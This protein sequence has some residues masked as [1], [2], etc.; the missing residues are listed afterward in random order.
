MP[1]DQKTHI[2]TDLNN[3]C[4]HHIP[5]PDQRKRMALIRQ[6]CE[7]TARFIRDNTPESR[8]Q[9]KAIGYLTDEVMMMLLSN[10]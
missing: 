2:D 4:R 9:S 8:E 5:S 10:T 1:I 6:K 3:R 7:E